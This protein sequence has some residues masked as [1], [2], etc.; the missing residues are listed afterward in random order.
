MGGEESALSPR[1]APTVQSQKSKALF[2]SKAGSWSMIH[3]M[4]TT[5][6]NRLQMRCSFW[7]SPHASMHT[8]LRKEWVTLRELICSPAGVC[9]AES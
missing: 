2:A 1:F 6:L 9:Q 5:T 3:E 7:G 8:G 4:A